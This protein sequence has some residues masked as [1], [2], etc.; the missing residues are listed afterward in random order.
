MIR[1]KLGD[2]TKMQGMDAIVNAAN[3]TLLGGGGVDAAIHAAAGPELLKEC[4]LL[5][6][7]KTGQAKISKAYNLPCQ[8]VIHTVGPIWH[9][10]NN[11]ER[12]L[13]FACYQNSLKLAAQNNIRR[14][15]FPSI[16]TGA[17][18][19]PVYMAAEIA[20]KA[21]R[22][23]LN[24]HQND[25]DEVVFVLF[26]SHTKFAY[27]QALKDAN[28][29]SLSDLVSKYDVEEDMVKI[30][31]EK[32]DDRYFFNNA[33]PAHFV[34][35]GL[36]YESV[37]EYLKAERAD[38]LF[39]YNEY[40]KLLLKANMAKYTQ[41]PALRGKLLATGDTTLCGGDSKD[42]ALGRCL[43]EIREK[44]RNEYIE[45]VVSVAE[46]E[47]P[48]QEEKAEEVQEPKAPVR[49]CIKDSALSAYAKKQLADK[50]EYEF[51]DELKALSDEEDAKLRD[52]IGIDAYGEV[53][54]FITE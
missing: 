1:T 42:N 30:G 2:I 28:K 4:K 5:D 6:G 38:N 7:C 26:D 19:F 39:D 31:A 15:A 29:E 22:T 24:E 14:I 8:Y 51:V 45:P 35:D 25:I 13:L 46:K 37:A 20:I 9:G 54:G 18:R 36:S 3:K 10:G 16:S 32:E 12:A 40:E 21:V 52:T 11:D 41:N 33:Y 23:F 34:L 49:V 53:K 44:F 27:D 17:Y 48:E 50:T 43:A 47:E